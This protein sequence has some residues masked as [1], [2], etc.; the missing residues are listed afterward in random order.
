MNRWSLFGL[1]GFRFFFVYFILYS[2]LTQIVNSI[3]FA[4]WNNAPDYATLWPIRLGVIWVAKDILQI[5]TEIVYADTGSGDKIFDW[6]LAFGVLVVSGLACAVWSLADRRSAGYPRLSNWFRL[7][8]RVALASQMFVYGFAKAVPLQMYYPFPFKFLEPLRNFSP[9]GVLWT[10]I[11]IS[12][13]YE[14]FLGCA[15]LLGGFLLI[16][17][18]TV[19]LG[20]LICLADVIQVFALNLTYDVCVKLFAF[21]LI[22]MSLL[23]LAP[24]L[25]RLW[26]FFFQGSQ[27]SLDQARPLFSSAR[28]NRLATTALAVLWCWMIA[29]NLL[30][31]WKGWHEVGGA[32]PESALA[33]IWNVEQLAINGQPEALTATNGGLWRR[34]T[35]DYPNWV[36]VQTMDD[37]IVA[38]S[39]SLDMQ[40]G[41]LTLTTSSNRNWR[42]NFLFN[43]PARDR[44][45][46]DGTVDGHNEHIQLMLMDAAQFPV[47]SRGFHWVQD[48]P[49]NH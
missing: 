16:F 21:Q 25:G 1:V 19:T 40:K 7:F 30:D 26:R 22:V 13:G 24:N 29:A 46:L 2:L 43:R 6:A 5:K 35:F 39:A 14:I 20:A 18:R 10:S 3:L 8:M 37:S 36:H 12:P 41:S 49:F 23:L 45:T 34:M 32:R 38:Y 33:G 9:M 4:Q 47:T 17:P 44:L 11:G 15:E 27:V 28:A 48:H 31:L 42:A